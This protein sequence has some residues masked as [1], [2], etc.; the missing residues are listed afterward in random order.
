MAKKV[1]VIRTTEQQV[2]RKKIILGTT[3]GIILT[4]LVTTG[5]TIPVVQAHKAL[6][7][8]TPLLR[9]SDVIFEM[10]LSDGSIYKLTYGDVKKLDNS[11]NEKAHLASEMNKHLVEYLYEK[12]YEASLKYEAIYNANKIAANTKTFAL[13]SV[14]KVRE[15]ITKEITE[16]ENKFK[17]QFSY[18]KKW[19]EKF[20]E[21]IA[22]DA[23]G[24]AKTKQE[25]IDYKVAQKMK[26]DAF[27]R[28]KFEINQDF[29]YN[30][31]KAGYITANSDVFYT[32]KGKKI[33]IAKKGDKIPLPFAKENQNYVLPPED[34]PE[35]SSNKKDTYKVHMFTTKSFDFGLKSIDRFIEAW[36]KLKQLITSE[37]KLAA[38][39]DK[40]RTK[41]WT[42][43]KDELIKLFSF[44]AY[45]SSQ[46][47]KTLVDM[48]INRLAHFKGIS[49]AL[50]NL[51]GVL[52]PEDIREALNDQT[53]IENISS[54]TTNA[55]KFGSE[56]FKSIE[57][58]ASNSDP[59][60]YMSLLSTLISKATSEDK[61]FKPEVKDNLFNTLREKLLEIF[62]S[63]DLELY[64]FLKNSANYGEVDS[65]SDYANKFAE[66]NARIKKVIER[67]F[68]KEKSVIEKEAGEA[69]RD[70]FK[71]DTSSITDPR[72]KKYLDGQISSIIKVGNNYVYAT[73][74]GI[75]IQNIFHLD[76]V[77]VI[78]SLIRRD[79]AIKSK[80]NYTSEFNEPLLSL[81]SMFNKLITSE[82]Q[83]NDLL[84]ND[85]DFKKFIKEKKYKDLS[86]NEKTFDDKTISDLIDYHKTLAGLAK[87]K[88]IDN[89]SKQI[90]DW[91]KKQ[92]ESHL[93]ADF[94][95]DYSKNKWYLAGH[96]DK[97]GKEN[98]LPYLFKVIQDYLIK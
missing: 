80:A 12:E 83:L 56:G 23:Y 65:S 15:K 53:A 22:K 57:D 36:A 29:T 17:E 95:R 28:Y 92:I 61:I 27:R 79:L 60:T 40:D 70:T 68:E 42:V 1:K 10:T 78:K 93:N 74:S 11:I 81:E 87:S 16:L 24:K 3:W 71:F 18:Q 64:N 30:E 97:M 52:K 4:G 31:L 55:K 20:K 44:S 5:I 47:G 41:P 13:D 67:R 69:F 33:Q 86:G 8:K 62:K 66:Y 72:L 45:R 48:G 96:E 59:S 54:S 91:M 38:K 34:S 73:S 89:K 43:T 51:D 77:D 63:E 98:I 49:S 90:K 26:D 75:T 6:P 84:T 88:L 14:E 2:K 25:A 35:L 9:D 94:R 7:K 21:E 82:F 85:P 58:R 19:E 32:Y 76:K 39:P 37:F 50:Q 46:T